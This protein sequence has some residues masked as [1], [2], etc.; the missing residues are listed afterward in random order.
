MAKAVK[1]L[2]KTKCK[3]GSKKAEQVARDLTTKQSEVNI[4]Y[5]VYINVR[6]R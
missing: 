4:V 3:E 1:S 2:E 5:M 6:P